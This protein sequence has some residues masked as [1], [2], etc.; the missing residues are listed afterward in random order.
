VIVCV[1]DQGPGIAPEDIPHVFDRFYRAP[2]MARQTK[3]AGLG[4]YL[5][6]AIIEG[7]DGRIWVDT[8]AGASTRFCFS[9]PRE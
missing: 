2:D 5:S 1:S 7:H 8:I 4:L 6:K 9:L 3:G